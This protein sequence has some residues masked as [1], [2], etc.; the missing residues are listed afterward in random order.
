[1]QFI[2]LNLQENRNWFL[3][4]MDSLTQQA[5]FRLCARE[6]KR[7]VPKIHGINATDANST[8]RTRYLRY[9]FLQLC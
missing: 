7:N 6:N 2:T 4:V 1:M 5:W 9:R 3:L 8:L